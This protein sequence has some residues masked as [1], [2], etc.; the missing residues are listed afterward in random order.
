MET[1]V[2]KKF[3]LGFLKCIITKESEAAPKE[4]R[5]EIGELVTEVIEEK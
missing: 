1:N 5:G 2:P 4:A 3:F